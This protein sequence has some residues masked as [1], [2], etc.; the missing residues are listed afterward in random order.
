MKTL[1]LTT[2]KLQNK[3]YTP[4][5]PDSNKSYMHPP[6]LSPPSPPIYSSNRYSNLSDVIQIPIINTSREVPST[7]KNW[8]GCIILI[9]GI[10]PILYQKLKAGKHLMG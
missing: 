7:Y 10:Q 2:I 1:S 3:K 5:S 9:N 4:S 8:I 6:S